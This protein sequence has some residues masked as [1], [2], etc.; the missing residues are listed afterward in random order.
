MLSQEMLARQIEA[1][2]QELA[3]ALGAEC[4]RCVAEMQSR[5]EALSSDLE[6]ARSL[7]Q[8]ALETR[9]SMAHDLDRARKSIAT[10]GQHLKEARQEAADAKAAHQDYVE[11][12]HQADTLRQ[13]TSALQDELEQE[14]SIRNRLEKGA[15]ADERRLHELEIALAAVSGDAANAVTAEALNREVIALQKSLQEALDNLHT[16]RAA[17]RGVEQALDEADRLIAALEEALKGSRQELKA[18]GAAASE[19]ERHA[20]EGQAE[21]LAAL[22]AQ[23]QREQAE[24]RK[25]AAAYDQA[26]VRIF[27]LENELHQG[28]SR[29]RQPPQASDEPRTATKPTRAKPLPHQ[30]HPAPRPGA[31]FHPD[32]ELR[33]LPCRSADQVVQAWGSVANVQ[34]ALEGYP[35]QYCAAFLVVLKQG[36]QKRLYLLFNLKSSRHILV[37]VPGQP[38][39][40][41]AAFSRH[42]NEARKYLQV[43][44][45]ELEKITAQ[46]IPTVLGRYFLEG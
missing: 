27:E 32:W 16:E 30:V 41:E 38:P 29:E 10:L 21:Q 37:C 2:S 31:R 24:Y 17:R 43:S 42:V 15:L 34:L 20:F 7:E 3:G 44:G 22:E 18:V 25:A 40:D 4:Q 33:G 26:M 13:E 23:L 1:M 39:A 14:R 36:R 6:A 19:E 28:D 12:L 8:A 5:I 46:E 35:S 9:Q 45:F 11:L